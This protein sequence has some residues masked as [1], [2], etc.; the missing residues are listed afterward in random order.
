QIAREAHWVPESKRVADLLPQ[1]QNE[2]FHIALVYDEHGSLTGLITLEDLLEELV[3]EIADEY[4]TEEAKIQPAGDGSYLVNG[5][6]PID[7]LN[8]TLGSE[9][10]DDEWDTVA[11]LMLNLVG[12]IPTEGQEV[13]FQGITFRAVQVQ[14]RRIAKVLVTSGAPAE[15]TVEEAKG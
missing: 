11:G 5:R 1:M 6:L 3:G 14:G 4:D 12:D 2:K 8:E 7:E 10:P 9:L 13:S 15:P